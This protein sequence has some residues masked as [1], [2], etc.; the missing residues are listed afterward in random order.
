MP[1]RLAPAVLILIALLGP[2][3]A[4]AADSD[5]AQRSALRRPLAMVPS[6][7]GR[8]LYVANRVGT[9]SVVDPVAGR[10]QSETPIG[11]RIS[12]LTA[13]GRDPSRLLA[14]DEEAGKLLLIEAGLDGVQKTV[15]LSMPATPVQVRTSPDG[16]LAAVSSLWARRLTLVSVTRDPAVAFGVVRA[17]D[18]PFAP[19]ELLFLPDG[20]LLVAD[21]HGGQLAIV[22]VAQAKIKLMRKLPGSNIRGL[23]LSPDGKKLLISHQILTNLAETTHNDI[24]WGILMTNLLR[25]LELARLYGPEDE[26]L[27]NRDR[28]SVV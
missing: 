1:T 21:S 13:L 14:T 2:I 17:V 18:L 7:D 28:K 19:R 12:S 27:K 10:I 3:R 20:A 16:S 15:E 5:L 8:R 25:W 26:L 23:A 4:S 22:D 11:K 9:L 24:H 6:T